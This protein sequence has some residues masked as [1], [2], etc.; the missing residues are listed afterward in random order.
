MYTHKGIEKL[1]HFMAVTPKKTANKSKGEWAVSNYKA[2]AEQR[3][4]PTEWKGNLQKGCKIFAITSQERGKFPEYVSKSYKS[5]EK[6][7]QT[8]KQNPH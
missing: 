6:Q 1:W 3:K 2:S 8:N 7:K 4:Q 5:R